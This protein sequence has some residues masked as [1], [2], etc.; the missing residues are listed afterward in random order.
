VYSPGGY[1]E[2][3]DLVVPELQRRG[4]LGTEYEASTL[5]EHYFGKGQRRA[6]ADHPASS[7]GRRRAPGTG[8][9]AERWLGKRGAAK[10][11]AASRPADRSRL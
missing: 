1:Q 7:Y 9:D 2:F 10:R 3:V 4:L 5:R 6:A 11:R 8:A